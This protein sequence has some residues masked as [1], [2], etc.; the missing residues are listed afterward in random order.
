MTKHTLRMKFKASDDKN[1][2]VSL[3]GCKGGIS[4]QDV[5]AAMDVM[6]ANQIFVFKL[7][8][9]RGAAV[10]ETTVTDLF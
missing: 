9:K 2:S 6:L 1:V 7:D 10:T 5:E 4:A 3:S 8:E